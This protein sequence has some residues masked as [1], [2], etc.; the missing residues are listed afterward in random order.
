VSHRACQDGGI[1][2]SKKTLRLACRYQVSLGAHAFA[3]FTSV[4]RTLVKHGANALVGDL[5]HLVQPPNLE[6]MA[7]YSIIGAAN[8]LHLMRRPPVRGRHMGSVRE[9]GMEC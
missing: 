8:Q 5:S 7:P 4:V 3:A 9:D 6:R 2:V 1:G